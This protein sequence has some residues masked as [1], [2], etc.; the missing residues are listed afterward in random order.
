MPE[1]QARHEVDAGALAEGEKVPAGHAV[2]AAEPAGQKKPTSQVAVQAL[3]ERPVPE[4]NVPAGHRV[5]AIA[6][7]AVE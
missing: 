7:A 3:V 2:C 5:Q 6:P 4:P 1:G